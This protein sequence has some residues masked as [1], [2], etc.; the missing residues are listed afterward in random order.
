M[1]SEIGGEITRKRNCAKK[2]SSTHSMYKVTAEPDGH[3]L[4]EVCSYAEVHCNV[5]IK[6]IV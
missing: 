3:H 6:R 2:R 4:K 5:M 1:V